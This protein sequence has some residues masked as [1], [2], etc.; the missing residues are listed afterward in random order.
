MTSK[1]RLKMAPE[2][3]ATDAAPAPAEWAVRMRA[4]YAQEGFYRPDDLQTLLGDP[5]TNVRIVQSEDAVTCQIFPTF[6][7]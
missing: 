3:S 6:P 2:S 1:A 7:N 4:H 5:R